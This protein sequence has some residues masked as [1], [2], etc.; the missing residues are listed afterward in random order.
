MREKKLEKISVCITESLCCNLQLPQH[1]KSTMLFKTIFLKECLATLN[2]LDY[3]SFCTHTSTVQ[4]DSKQLA[5][6]NTETNYP[7]CIL[8]TSNV[9]SHPFQ[10]MQLGERWGPQAWESRYQLSHPS[11][12]NTLSVS[13]FL[14]LESGNN[15]RTYRTGLFWGLNETTRCKC[16]EQMLK[17]RTCSINANCW[18][19][20]YR[21]GFF[22]HILHGSI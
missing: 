7:F 2:H 6:D 18:N 13:P 10:E 8:S 15:N 12:S 19:N 21:N 16:L 3:L 9:W 20:F 11:P 17:E 22:P 14:Y 1:C 5:Y 4:K